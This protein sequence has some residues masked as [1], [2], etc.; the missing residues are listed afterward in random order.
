MKSQYN[1]MQHSLKDD[2]WKERFDSLHLTEIAD[3]FPRDVIQTEKVID[4]I[5]HK[6]NSCL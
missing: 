5:F 4:L 2:Y 3:N 6:Y 1:K